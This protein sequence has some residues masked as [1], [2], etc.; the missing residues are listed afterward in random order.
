M[1]ATIKAAIISGTWAPGTYPGM[2]GATAE[3]G[4]SSAATHAASLRL[5]HTHTENESYKDCN[6]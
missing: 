2:A 4:V 3:S 5:Q 1:A 6:D